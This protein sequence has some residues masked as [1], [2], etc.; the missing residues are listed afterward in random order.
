MEP[1]ESLPY[2][3]RPEYSSHF[4]V[5]NHFEVFLLISATEISLKTKQGE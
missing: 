4:T 3:R 1:E 5:H 2:S